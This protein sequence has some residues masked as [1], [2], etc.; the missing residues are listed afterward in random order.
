MAEQNAALKKFTV[1][2][3]ESAKRRVFRDL[4]ELGKYTAEV[5]LRALDLLAR[6]QGYLKNPPKPDS[7]EALA[8]QKE[9]A[10]VTQDSAVLLEDPLFLDEMNSGDPARI[11]ALQLSYIGEMLKFTPDQ[12]AVFTR[13][14]A[15][16][17][18]NAYEQKLEWAVTDPR[19]ADINKTT[20]AAISSTFTP[21]QRD[22]WNRA[23]LNRLL[24]N[25]AIGAP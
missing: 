20:V 2:E 24:F 5:S 1:A 17:Y 23:R 18:R 16:A 10:Q 7:P 11:T 21:E 15:Q 8:L 12:R 6:Y 9:F 25:F 14:V 22:L 13:E 19:L 4:D 3:Q